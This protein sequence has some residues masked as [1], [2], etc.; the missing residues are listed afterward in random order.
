VLDAGLV[1]ALLL[2][3]HARALSG[4]LV[5]LEGT[6]LMVR[7]E[8]QFQSFA[9]SERAP[10]ER[11]ST[12]EGAS[13]TARIAASDLT[14]GEY[15]ELEVDAAGIVSRVRA[16][17]LVETARVRSASG[18]NVLLEDGTA[19]SIGSVLRFVDA[20]GEPA[21]KAAL[22]PGDGVLLFRHPETRIV[23]RFSPAPR[24]GERVTRPRVPPRKER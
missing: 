16:V 11:R 9:L 14:P 5:S 6:Q 10:V 7:A 3:P 21:P 4:T 1:F 24:P 23:Y 22:K 12:L 19:L 13:T 18:A 17:A 8:R 20:R 2:G 15:V